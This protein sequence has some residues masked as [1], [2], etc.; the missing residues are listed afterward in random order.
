VFTIA[1]GT[2]MASGNN[3]NTTINKSIP[4]AHTKNNG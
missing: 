2:G 3:S 1:E 4:T